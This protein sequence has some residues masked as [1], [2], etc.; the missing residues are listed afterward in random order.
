MKKASEVEL[1]Q[2]KRNVLVQ[3]LN[4]VSFLRPSKIRELLYHTANA[5]KQEA[6]RIAWQ[7][8]QMR[9]K[10]RIDN[11]RRD[12]KVAAATVLY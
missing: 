1:R 4:D 9:E 3:H 8:R 6:A 5:R 2:W 10:I 7:N 11:L 12:K